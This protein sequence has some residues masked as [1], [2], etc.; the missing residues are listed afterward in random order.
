MMVMS[1]MCNLYTLSEKERLESGECEFDH[2]GYFIIRGKER[3]IV[4][5]ERINYN[6]V[7]LF[8]P[9]LNSKNLIQA[10]I[11]SMSE[12]TGHSVFIQMK[13]LQQDL[14]MCMNIPYVTS[15]I[16]V[17]Y[18]LRA[19]ECSREEVDFLLE[20]MREMMRQS[21]CEPR[22]AQKCRVMLTGIL[23]DYLSMS[24][25]EDVI[26]YLCQHA[27]YTVTKDR[28]VGYVDQII[29]NEI[30]PHLGISST[31][32]QK[33]LFLGHMMKRITAVLVGMVP[34][35]DR[36][37]VSNKRIETTGVLIG[38]LFRTLYKRMIRSI[39]PHLVKRPDIGIILTRVNSVTLAKPKSRKS[40]RVPRAIISAVSDWRP[41]GGKMRVESVMGIDFKL[42]PVGGDRKFATP[43]VANP[44]RSLYTPILQTARLIKGC[45]GGL[46]RSML[47]RTAW[48][49][50][51]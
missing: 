15:E 6:I 45:R 13:L 10:E 44:L 7:Y 39:E 27:S 35:D 36:D 23:H 24:H 30:F 50:A 22:A 40:R 41:S 18:M 46:F 4:A 31:R 28:K 19:Y 51:A 48:K 33:V 14:R 43:P 17:G 34:L 5:Q 2:G 42:N 3:V 9:K 1:S 25:K 47:R 21:G 11:R 20:E 12:E 32:L 29:Y 49:H 16:P 38:D 8:E 26:R 37:H